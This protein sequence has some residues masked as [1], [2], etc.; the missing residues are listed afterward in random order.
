MTTDKTYLNFCGISVFKCI[1]L[2]MQI[3]EIANDIELKRVMLKIN[4]KKVMFVNV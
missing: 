3:R 1:F 2:H 4:T